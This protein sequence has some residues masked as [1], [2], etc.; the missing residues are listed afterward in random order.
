MHTCAPFLVSLF[1]SCCVCD[2][3]AGPF[4]RGSG[5]GGGGPVRDAERARGQGCRPRGRRGRAGAR[6]RLRGALPAGFVLHIQTR[7]FHCRVFCSFRFVSFFFFFNF[8]SSKTARPR[9]LT[10]Q[11]PLPL[12]MYVCVGVWVWVCLCGCVGVFFLLLFSNVS[13]NSA[14]PRGGPKR[15]RRSPKA[16]S[17]N[18]T[19]P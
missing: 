18:P 13:S 19:R 10:V 16:C 11:P 9:F 14:R 5:G 4:K 3:G 17:A 1:V 2:T 12:C 15:R 7:I 6:P 8:K